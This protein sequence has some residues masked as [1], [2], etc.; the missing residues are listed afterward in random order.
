MMK[1]EDTHEMRQRVYIEDTDCYGA[2]PTTRVPAPM[3]NELTG[4]LSIAN[5]RMHGRRR[6]LRELP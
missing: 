3:A 2:P 4:S 1:A 5:R 6:I